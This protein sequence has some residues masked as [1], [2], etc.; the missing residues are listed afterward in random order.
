MRLGL[1]FHLSH[2]S[3]LFKCCLVIDL[4]LFCLSLNILK[5]VMMFLVFGKDGSEFKL[6]QS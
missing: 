6:T 2:A 4:S 3:F 5:F 1:E